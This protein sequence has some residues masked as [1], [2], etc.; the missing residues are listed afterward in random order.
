MDILPLFN[1]I[2]QSAISEKNLL[3]VA[4]IIVLFF[5]FKLRS[6][7]NTS[8]AFSVSK[9]PV[10]SSANIISGEFINALDIAIL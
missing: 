8:F 5:D 2:L 9:L 4:K 6:I 7:L 1:S 3:C 10:G